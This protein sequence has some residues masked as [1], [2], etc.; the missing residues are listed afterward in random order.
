MAKMLNEYRHWVFDL[1]GTLTQPVHDFEHI[2]NE[3][4]IPQNEDILAYLNT[5]PEA[6]RLEKSERLDQLEH[7][8]ALQAKPADGVYGLLEYLVSQAC[9]LG[10]LTRNT[11]EFA[12]LS[13]EALG[14]SQ[15]FCEAEVIGR[16]DAIPKPDP[17]GIQHLAQI[18]KVPPASLLMVGDYRYDLLAGRAANCTTVHV[19]Q[20]DEHHWP[21]LTDHR[22]SSL[23]DLH[24]TLLETV[25]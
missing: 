24:N 13:L 14:V 18:W 2:R 23:R 1:D 16:D 12:L 7:F 4:G 11:R 25:I 9:T 19:Y 8:Y 5:L 10:I 20:S 3:L 22:F 6:L 17:Q 15:Y 21:E